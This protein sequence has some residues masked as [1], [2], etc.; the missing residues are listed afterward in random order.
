LAEG[1]KLGE[2]AFIIGVLIAIVIGLFS[3]N[4]ETKNPQLSGWLVAALVLLG[5]VVGLMNISEKETTPFL[6]AAITLL[7]AG[8]AQES[9]KNIPT[10]GRYLVDIVKQIGVF[11]SPAAIVVA[12]KAIQS[13]AKD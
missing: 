1:K 10:I 2:W 6:V 4:I 11:V 5:L 9:L 13:L 3:S 12:L 8:S 7:A